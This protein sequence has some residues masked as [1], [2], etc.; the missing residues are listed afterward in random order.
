[1]SKRFYNHEEAEAVGVNDERILNIAHFM[2][3]SALDEVDPKQI[4]WLWK[5]H[6]VRAAVNLWAGNPGIGKSTLSCDFA[7]RISRGDH[8][9]F[10]GEGL[11][12]P[13]KVLLCNGEDSTATTL[14]PRL[15]AVGADLSKIIVPTRVVKTNADGQTTTSMLEDLYY[16]FEVVESKCR[17]NPEIR[18]VIIDPITAYMGDGDNNSTTEV[19]VLVKRMSDIAAALD[20][21]FL[22]VTH[23]NKKTE[24]DGMFR[25]LGS[26]AWVAG[27]RVVFA[28]EELQKGVEGGIMRP[29]KLNLCRRP[30]PKAYRIV[31]VSVL[32]HAGQPVQT[33]KVEWVAQGE[34]EIKA[35][36]KAGMVEEMEEGKTVQDSRSRTGVPRAVQAE[37]FLRVYLKTGPCSPKEIIQAAKGVGIGELAIRKA[38]SRLGLTSEQQRGVCGRMWNLADLV[39]PS[40]A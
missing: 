33:S 34:E 28:F 22:L 23:N 2:E 25:I 4:R 13:A 35:L 1:M 20:V 40:R 26:I 39:E 10:G 30:E 31:E 7:S 38:A 24:M 18:L 29:V 14:V 19:R 21:T 8:M 6:V 15:M 16:Q 27:A 37:Q 32:D 5:G 11:G 3:T 36:K 12:V 9:P 17:N